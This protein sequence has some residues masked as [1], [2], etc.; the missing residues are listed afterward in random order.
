MVIIF[1]PPEPAAVAPAPLTAIVSRARDLLIEHQAELFL[2]AGAAT[3]EIVR[4]RSSSFGAALA[5]QAHEL[6][7]GPRGRQVAGLVVFGAGAVP[8]LR[9]SDARRLVR[10]A[11]SGA[12]RA[13]T[14]NRYSSDVC[15][16][17]DAAVLRDLPALPG[18]NALPRWLAERAGVA[19]EELPG[20]ERLAF[21]LD[22]PLD[23]AL[24][25][26]VSGAPGPLR[27]LA[28]AAGLAV[29]R[30]AELRALLGDRTRELLVFGRG[31]AH[32][33]ARLE[34]DAACRVRFL[35]EERGLRGATA[36][37]QGH[38]P[39]TARPPHAT[40]GRL[41]AARGGPA[42]LG[43]TI[44]E[45]ADGAVLDSRVLLADRLGADERSWPGAE[46]RYASD[47]LRPVAIR[48]A[49]LRDLTAAAS[50]SPLPILLGGHTLVGPGLRILLGTTSGRPARPA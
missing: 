37:A 8:F 34:R 30:L 36:L 11:A 19:V 4:A 31:S 25:A 39:A 28:V 43:T 46:D 5:H 33:L 29:P 13:L 27:R 40:L 15:A 12:R 20:R 23:L 24:L 22:T 49:W 42:S 35:A 16:I 9:R 45:L 50:A 1:H 2:A 41:L 7:G 48:D 32:G 3:V 10:L 38:H 17:G 6:A 18:D 26:L 21:D 47:L 14:N 44:A